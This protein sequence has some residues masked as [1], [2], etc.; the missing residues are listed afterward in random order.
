MSTGSWN[1]TSSCGSRFGSVT[2]GRERPSNAGR[3]AREEKENFE[4]KI[5]FVFL[6]R[7]LQFA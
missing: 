6:K 1:N 3:T 2:F 7:G 4:K 5:E